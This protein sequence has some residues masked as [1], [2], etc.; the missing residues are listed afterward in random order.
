MLPPP[1]YVHTVSEE[2]A[3]TMADGVRIATTVTYP[4]LDGST[5]A[6]GPFPIVLSITPYG[7]NMPLAGAPG[8]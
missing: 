4:S 3:V 8:R 1:S 7:R 2:V 6:P 5:P